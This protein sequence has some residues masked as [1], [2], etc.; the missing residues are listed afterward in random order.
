MRGIRLAGWS[1][2]PRAGGSGLGAVRDFSRRHD[3]GCSCSHSANTGAG[4]GFWATRD[5]EVP[6]SH[7]QAME[8]GAPVASAAP[9]SSEKPSVNII[10]W[11]VWISL[12]E[13][14]LNTEFPREL[15]GSEVSSD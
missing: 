9:G 2:P 5:V 7:T 8:T 13:I 6:S 10:L 15:H 12:G 3:I 1:G 11:T 14:L 4:P